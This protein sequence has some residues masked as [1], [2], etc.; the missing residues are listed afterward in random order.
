V[1]AEEEVDRQARILEA[2]LGLLAAQKR[3]RAGLAAL[4]RAAGPQQSPAECNRRA[5]DIDVLQNG[6][7]LS[8]SSTA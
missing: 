2:V 6:L 1:R 5:A 4:I 3:Y 8:A 7:W